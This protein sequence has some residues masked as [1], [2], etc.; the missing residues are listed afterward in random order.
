MEHE[1][2]AG[3]LQTG[4]GEPQEHLGGGQHDHHRSDVRYG[5]LAIILE[6]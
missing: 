2:G 3:Q 6:L 5:L 4:L 1:K